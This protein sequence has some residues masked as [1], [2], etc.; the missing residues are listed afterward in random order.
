M[1]NS[2][3]KPFKIRKIFLILLTAFGIYFLGFGLISGFYL[4]NNQPLP[5]PFNI[6]FS[7]LTTHISEKG[8]FAVPLGL[9]LFLCESIFGGH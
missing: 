4:S 3:S 7:P 1:S 9:Y 8:I 5:Q 6:A 2:G